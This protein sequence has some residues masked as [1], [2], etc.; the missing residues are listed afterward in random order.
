MIL[1]FPRSS[2][3]RAVVVVAMCGAVLFPAWGMGARMEASAPLATST[4]LTIGLTS[5]I[6]TF[7]PSLNDFTLPRGWL[8]EPV[9]DTLV[10]ESA[11]GKYVPNLAT[12]WTRPNPNTFV[13][14][15]RTGVKFADGSAFNAAAVKANVDHARSDNGPDVS[16]LANIKSVSVVNAETV[17]L[18]LSARSYHFRG[19]PVPFPRG[20]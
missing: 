8:L 10:R 7:D 14:T 15:L 5:A 12:H 1:S 18:N 2:V 20:V 9:Y 11:S 17:K 16:L 3:L 6:E 13:M 4:T 19:R